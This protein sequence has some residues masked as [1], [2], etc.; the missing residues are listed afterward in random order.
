MYKHSHEAIKEEYNELNKCAKARSG[1]YTIKGKELLKED[2][3][4]V[5]I[6]G[7][8]AKETTTIMG[9]EI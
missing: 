2:P 1:I 8:K 4:I 3:H 5:R 6:D 9:L 7:I